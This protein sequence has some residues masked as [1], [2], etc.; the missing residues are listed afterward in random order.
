MSE[1]DFREIVADYFLWSSR[2]EQELLQALA[3][4]A[5]EQAARSIGISLGKGTPDEIQASGGLGATHHIQNL[6]GTAVGAGVAGAMGCMLA[7]LLV[8]RLPTFLAASVAASITSAL[9]IK[10]LARRQIS[11]P[12]VSQFSSDP[13]TIDLGVN[14]HGVWEKAAHSHDQTLILPPP[15]RIGDGST[16][17]IIDVRN[18]DNK[19]NCDE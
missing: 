7:E 5:N 16:A 11:D 10:L 18:Q 2:L 1:S 8:P 6:L 14:Q 15:Q 12:A 17:R 19:E 9:A 3:L 13:I 4:S